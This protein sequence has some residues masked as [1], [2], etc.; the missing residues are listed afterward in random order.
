M[1]IKNRLKQHIPI[2]ICKTCGKIALQ[3]KVLELE[4]PALIKDMRYKKRKTWARIMK[5]SFNIYYD[6]Q[7]KLRN[8]RIFYSSNVA[9][10]N[11]KYR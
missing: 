9:W 6:G 1:I 3:D 4:D 5:P 8:K 7:R 2:I 10:W 11:K